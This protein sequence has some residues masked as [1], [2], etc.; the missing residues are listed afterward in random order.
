MR[1]SAP[2]STGWRARAGCG[3]KR[4]Q[5]TPRAAD[6]RCDTGS[7]RRYRARR[8]I[9][10]LARTRCPRDFRKGRGTY[11]Q[12][13]R[14]PGFV[15]FGSPPCRHFPRIQRVRTLI[16]HRP[17]AANRL[18]PTQSP[19]APVPP[20][21]ISRQ[22]PTRLPTG[23]ARGSRSRPGPRTPAAALL[24]GRRGHGTRAPLHPGAGPLTRAAS[25]L[26]DDLDQSVGGQPPG[27]KARQLGSTQCT[28]HLHHGIYCH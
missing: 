1:R 8:R 2:R 24:T 13:C 22:A 18:P 27:P 25:P 20:V 9:D 4:P 5:R 15:S 11:C 28:A 12:N 6:R 17:R 10:E 19:P 3:Q 21:R 7:T 16:E 14:N 23:T 26:G